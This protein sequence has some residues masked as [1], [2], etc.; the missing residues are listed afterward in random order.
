ML[1][2]YFCTGLLL[3]LAVGFLF[4]YTAG[5]AAAA[6]LFGFMAGNFACSLVHRL[7]RGKSILANTPYCGSC[8]H[9]LSER[10]LLPV[11]GALMLRHRCRYC[12][13]SFPTSHTWTELL[14]GLLFVLAFLHYGFSEQ[15]LLTIGLGTFLITLAAIEVNDGII[16]GKIELC[17]MVFGM[18]NRTLID[19]T[20][21]NFFDGG[22]I[23]LL[24]GALLWFRKIKPKGH[25]YTLPKPVEL[26]ALGGICIGEERLP[27]FLGLFAAFYAA[28]WVICKILRAQQPPAMTIAFGLAVVIPVLYP[29][30]IELLMR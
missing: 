27:V 18:I 14:I 3:A 21:Y 26:L 6:L 2:R 30:S 24:I 17:V 19:S 9:A 12:G 15:F 16:L 11:I 13:V 20:I 4:G 28:E 8:N 23:S 29:G 5:G 7:P 25:I 10:D 22:L 1:T